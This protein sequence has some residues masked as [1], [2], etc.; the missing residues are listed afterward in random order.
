[1]SSHIC[2]SKRHTGT[3]LSFSPQDGYGF[4]KLVDENNFIIPDGRIYAHAREVKG[5][6]IQ[7]GDLVTF[8]L[9]L[10]KEKKKLPEA[11]EIFGGSVPV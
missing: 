8:N 6:C 3:V 2:S 9:V 1:M 7:R 4:I 10:S 11:Q 5:K